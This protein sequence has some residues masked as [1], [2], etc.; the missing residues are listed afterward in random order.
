M[1]SGAR[2]SGFCALT[3]AQE[4]HHS[5]KRKTPKRVAWWREGCLE[6]NRPRDRRKRASRAAA[7]FGLQAKGCLLCSKRPIASAKISAGEISP[8]EN[9]KRWSGRRRCPPSPEA[10]GNSSEVA[11]QP[12]AARSAKSSTHP[13]S[14]EARNFAPIGRPSGIRSHPNNRDFLENAESHCNSPKFCSFFQKQRNFR[15]TK[16][17]NSDSV[18]HI[19][20]VL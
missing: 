5:Q 13:R 2:S 1:A 10:G 20:N 15:N 6:R 16:M 4:K 7:S 14:A 8:G 18:N 17:K 3:P 9:N 12:A 19:P 11:A